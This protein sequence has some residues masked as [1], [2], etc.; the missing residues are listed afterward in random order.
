MR[1]VRKL[2]YIV[3]KTCSTTFLGNSSIIS[4][5]FNKVIS[6]NLRHFLNF[7]SNLKYG[8]K[9]T[10]FPML[11][12]D[13]LPIQ[14]IV[15]KFFSKMI[16]TGAPELHCYECTFRPNLTSLTFHSLWIILNL[17]IPIFLLIS[18]THLILIQNWKFLDLQKLIKYFI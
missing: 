7:H 17:L 14:N 13:Y 6:N 12:G 18:D 15:G 1:Y 16:F 10:M 5:D 4:V 3:K 8:R 9:I 11:S 2:R